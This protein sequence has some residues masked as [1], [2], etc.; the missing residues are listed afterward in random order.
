MWVIG[1]ILYHKVRFIYEITAMYKLI[2]FNAFKEN[3]FRNFGYLSKYDFAVPLLNLLG[4]L[5][6][7]IHGIIMKYLL[8][9][10]M[11]KSVNWYYCYLCDRRHCYLVW[12]LLLIP[13][14]Q[15]MVFKLRLYWKQQFKASSH[16][17]KHIAEKMCFLR[18][19]ELP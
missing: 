2:N 4:I 6:W 9:I 17:A 11:H 1:L 3:E 13:V 8:E 14:P 10:W 12:R 19:P 5:Y 7:F 15:C 18:H 16:C